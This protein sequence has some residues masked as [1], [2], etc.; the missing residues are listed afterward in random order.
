M[1][2]HHYLYLALTIIT[3]ALLSGFVVYFTSIKLFLKENLPG[4]ITNNVSENEN[5]NE[6]E[7]IVDFVPVDP[8]AP[9]ALPTGTV[10][11]VT[12]CER[13]DNLKKCLKEKNPNLLGKVTEKN[14]TS[15]ATI[16]EKCGNTLG[17]INELR[18]ESIKS[19]CIY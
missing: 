1:K 19:G 12:A 4:A 15:G 17:D 7:T 11:G 6:K 9:I 18:M 14:A 2:S 8:E 5:E 3:V 10:G 16:E 13:L